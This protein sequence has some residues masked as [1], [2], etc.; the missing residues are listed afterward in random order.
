[1][2]KLYHKGL[3]QTHSNILLLGSASSFKMPDL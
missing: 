2:P 3:P 1:L